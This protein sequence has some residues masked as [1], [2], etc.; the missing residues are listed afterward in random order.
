M[1]AHAMLKPVYFTFV[2]TML[3]FFANYTFCYITSTFAKT[4]KQI[5]IAMIALRH[6]ILLKAD[7]VVGLYAHRLFSGSTCSCKKDPRFN[8]QKRT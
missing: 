8:S 6:T 1:A 7:P 4:N 5:I 3:E 2:N